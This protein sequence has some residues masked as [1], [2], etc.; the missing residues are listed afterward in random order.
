MAKFSDARGKGLNIKCSGRFTRPG[1]SSHP[2]KSRFE[3]AAKSFGIEERCSEPVLAKGL[4]KRGRALAIRGKACSQRHKFIGIPRH[5]FGD[6][7]SIKQA[8]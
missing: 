5:Q 3:M 2:G 6:T 4:A 7:G 8:F 1:C